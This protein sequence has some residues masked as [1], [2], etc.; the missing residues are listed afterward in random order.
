[1]PGRGTAGSVYALLYYSGIFTALLTAFYTFR[2]YF[3]TFHGPER[4]PHEAGQHAHESPAVMTWPLAILAL[5]ALTLGAVFEL[6]V[7]ALSSFL[8]R[9]PSLAYLTQRGRWSRPRRPGAPEYHA[10]EH[11][12]G[13]G[14]HRPGGRALPGFAG[15]PRRADS[16][17][18]GAGAVRPVGRQVLFR[19]AYNVFFVWPLRG[20]AWAA[21]CLTGHHRRPGRPGRPQPVRPGRL[22]RPLQGGMLQFYALAMLLGV[23]VLM[24]AMWIVNE[25]QFTC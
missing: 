20:V 24:W 7:A 15:R 8:R 13:R 16:R 12:G 25:I 11:A 23:L 17:D 1:M 21:A 4:I 22:L 19:S 10:G 14:G 3:L 2:A 6:Q 9:T 5:G 18:E